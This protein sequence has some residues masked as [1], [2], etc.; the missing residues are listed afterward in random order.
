MQIRNGLNPLLRLG[1]ALVHSGL[2]MDLDTHGG[3]RARFLEAGGPWGA[4]VPAATRLGVYI[5]VSKFKGHA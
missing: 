3:G 2:D 1:R 5:F 4:V